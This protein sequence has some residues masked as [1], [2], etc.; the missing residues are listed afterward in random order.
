[1][2]VVPALLEEAV[3][4]E[5]PSTEELVSASGSRADLQAMSQ[6]RQV[7]ALRRDIEKTARRPEFRFEGSYG[8][9]AIKVD[10]LFDSNYAGWDAGVFMEWHLYDGRSARSRIRQV[11]SQNRRNYLNAAARQ[12]EI[13]RDLVSGIENYN[14]ARQATEAAREAIREAEEAHRVAMEEHQWGAAT[15]LQVLEAER[16]LTETRFQRLDAVHDALAALADVHFQ[17]GRMPQDLLS[18]EG[19]P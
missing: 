10:N 2:G 18:G 7:L 9:T 15:V 8:I 3:L 19:T 12:G 11:E 17:I 5:L 14:R 16:T 6:E 4:P 13:A 1:V